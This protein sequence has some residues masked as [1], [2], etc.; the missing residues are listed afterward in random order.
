MPAVVQHERLRQ[1]R[2]TAAVALGELM[3]RDAIAM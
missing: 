3:A 1:S 2:K